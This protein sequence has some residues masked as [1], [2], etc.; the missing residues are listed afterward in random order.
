V[1]VRVLFGA[2]EGPA[3]RG[4]SRVCASLSDSLSRARQLPW[5]HRP[6]SLP[7]LCGPDADVAP[8][9]D[10][11]TRTDG[12]TGGV[13]VSQ[14]ISVALAS[15]RNFRASLPHQLRIVPSAVSVGDADSRD[16]QHDRHLVAHEHTAACQSLLPGEAEVCAV[17]DDV[18]PEA[19]TFVPPRIRAGTVHDGGK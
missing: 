18:G 2:S 9:A 12:C 10:P 6:R 15:A 19:Y 7:M 17:D 16:V 13:P 4:L 14:A 8:D 11:Q 1:E 3:E 5:Q